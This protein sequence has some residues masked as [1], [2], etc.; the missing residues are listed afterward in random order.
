MLFCVGSVLNLFCV[1]Y[2]ETV[3]CVAE[4]VLKAEFPLCM[5]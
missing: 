5:E 1:K 2:L 4:T 3:I